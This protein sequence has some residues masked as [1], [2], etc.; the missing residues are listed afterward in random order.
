MNLA[1]ALFF[2]P[3][4]LST[5]AMSTAPGGGKTNLGNSRLF[6]G[7]LAS[8]KTTP[9]EIREIFSKYGKIT[10]DIVLHRSFGFVQYDNPESAAAAINMENGRVL[11]GL[12][13]GIILLIYLSAF[14]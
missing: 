6:I 11:G 12:R 2:D 14:F 3:C 8:E 5:S 4:L 13:L 10:E 9:K 1:E 7:N